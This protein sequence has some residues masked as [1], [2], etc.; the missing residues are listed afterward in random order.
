MSRLALYA[1]ALAALLALPWGI[2]HAGQ[3][4]VQTRWDAEKARVEAD[5]QRRLK[6][7]T[8]DSAITQEVLASNKRAL[9]ELQGQLAKASQKKTLTR[10]V[11]VEVPV[12]AP[13]SCPVLDSEFVRLFD[14]AHS[15]PSPAPTR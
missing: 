13:C 11:T 14:A 7:V 4:S 2:Y 5:Y 9:L 8:D 15:G 12:N 10:T 6:A 3:R 1:I